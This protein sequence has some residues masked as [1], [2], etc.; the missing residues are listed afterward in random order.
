M[1]G[2]VRQAGQVGSAVNQYEQKKILSQARPRLAAMNQIHE[3]TKGICG[4]AHLQ[5]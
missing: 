1:Q 2:P 4:L 3:R 5:I